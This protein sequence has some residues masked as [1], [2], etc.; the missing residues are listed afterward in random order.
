MQS[1][2]PRSRNR[3]YFIIVDIIVTLIGAEGNGGS[4]GN[5]MPG[6]SFHTSL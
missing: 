4:I 2:P 6:S 1:T 5:L 3:S